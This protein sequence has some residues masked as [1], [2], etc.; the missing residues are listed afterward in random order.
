MGVF[1]ATEK[2]EFQVTNVVHDHHRCVVKVT[3]SQYIEP[4]LRKKFS[5]DIPEGRL[6]SVLE[7]LGFKNVNW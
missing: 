6:R 4:N 1:K 5:V 7:S 2:S 3:L